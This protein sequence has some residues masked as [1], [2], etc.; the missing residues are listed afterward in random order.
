[1]TESP[2]DVLNDLHRALNLSAGSHACACIGIKK[3]AAEFA[4]VQGAVP[5]TPENPDPTL[6]FG[7][8]DPND[9]R[10]Q[11]YARW[12]VADVPFQ[13]GENGPVVAQLGRQWLISVYTE[14]DTSFRPR[15]ARALG[16]DLD[17]IHVSVYGDLRRLRHDLVHRRGVASADNSGRCEV[18][19]WAEPGAEIVITGDHIVDFMSRVGQDVER[20]IT[21]YRPPV[22]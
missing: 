8:G 2:D 10:T 18:L 19:R 16:T 5:R 9:P 12:R 7:T 17:K 21:Q 11:M 1:M 3:L 14:W 4:A 15:L 6:Y 13:L 20:A 22:G